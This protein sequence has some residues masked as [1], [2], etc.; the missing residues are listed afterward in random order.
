MHEVMKLLMKFF[1]AIVIIFISI[2]C[3]SQVEK[4]TTKGNMTLGGDFNV[5]FGFQNSSYTI[6]QTP[7]VYEV[8]NKNLGIS[9]NPTFGY[10]ICNGLILGLSPSYVYN[11][12]KNITTNTISGELNN[13]NSHSNN[14]GV[15]IF[16]K[17]YFKNSIFV[18]LESGY[19][20]GINKLSLVEDIYK[21]STFSLRPSLG[22]AIFINSKISIEPSLNYKI[23]NSHLISPQQYSESYKTPRHNFF[24]AVGFH[25]FL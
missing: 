22:Y 10:F 2:D 19:E 4:P 20:Y 17:Y 6:D 8:E 25:L 9:I 13:D 16:L 23:T 1:F 24:I 21:S 12:D 15:N 18:R 11:Y 7:G 14:I 3:F 5:N